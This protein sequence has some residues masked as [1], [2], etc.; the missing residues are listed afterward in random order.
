MQNQTSSGRLVR[1]LS[2]L[3]CETWLIRPEMHKTLSDIA[4]A[5]SEGG[6]L[7]DAQHKLASAMKKNPKAKEYGMAG[8][9]AVVPVEGVI[10]RKFSNTLR[11]SGVVSVDVFE[12]LIRVAADDDDVSSI[13]LS[14]DSPGGI[15]MGVPEA[16]AAVAYANTIK[17]V[18]AYADGLMD[19][20]AYW[21]AT[22]ASAI[23]ATES[24]KVG[25]I[26]VYLAL[27][28][29]SR[30]AEM[31]GLKVEMIKSGKYKGM[32]YPGTSLTEPQREMLQSKVDKLGDKFRSAVRRGRA[33]D[34][35]DDVMQGQSFSVEDAL[36]NGL[37]DGVS[38]MAKAVRDAEAL[39]KLRARR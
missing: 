35:S 6:A 17:P 20:A 22:N 7:E 13:V 12:R 33:R 9:T 11:S 32:G 26:G 15:A 19:S 18:I 2:A 1:V 3:Y 8:S 5:H 29:Q 14:F 10:G 31:A 37:I 39:A 27:L 16:A 28:D 36:A 23:Y 25:S 38:D 34:I 4:V 21:L 30:A 24:A